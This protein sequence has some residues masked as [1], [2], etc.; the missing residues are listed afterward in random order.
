MK[1]LNVELGDR[2]Y[3]IYIGIGLLE[4]PKI[5]T[6]HIRTKTICIVSNTTVSKLYL[7]VIKNFL[8][9]YQVV[10]A[11]IDDGEEFKNHDSLNYIYTKLLEN[12]CNRDTT[13]LALGGGVVGD[14]AGYA[15]AS[16]LRGIPFVQIPTTLLA[17]VDSSVGGKTG[18]NHLL[19]KNM[20][21]AFYQPQ[22]VV[23]DLNVLKTLDNRQISAGLAEIIKYG[24]IWDEDFFEYLEQNID[25]LKQLDFEHLEH[26]IYRSCEIK[27]KVVSEDEKE[28]GIR[29][30]LNLGHT[31]GHAIENCL[32]YGEWLHG[33]AVGCGM[34]LA[35]KMSLAQGWLCE[36]EF[37]RVKDLIFQA[38][39][40]IEKPKID[41]ENFIGA[42]KLDK[43]NKDKEIYLVLQQGI[44]KAIV[45]NEYSSNIL[46]EIIKS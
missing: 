22:A 23:I 33:E 2:S 9:D 45:T 28:S 4:D 19:G 39:L 37:D 44:G 13:I 27:A 21:G 7:E 29:A 40:P 6:S 8:D 14:I 41:Y 1:I 18:I 12:Q 24:L 46:D 32:G 3:P 15:A 35:A 34:V 17:Q 16:F 31:F 43:K 30:I 20:I 5:I 42:M 36:S 26:V 10:E 11:I 38:N 25:N